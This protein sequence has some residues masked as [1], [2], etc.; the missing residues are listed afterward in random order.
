[1]PWVG[2]VVP[3]I[4]QDVRVDEE[5]GAFPAGDESA[6]LQR[7]VGDRDRRGAHLELGGQPADRREGLVQGVLPVEDPER[8][9]APDLLLEALRGI[10]VEHDHVL[11]HRATSTGVA[12]PHTRAARGSG[13]WPLAA[14][15]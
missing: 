3:R 4:G 12:R 7:L 5:P 14:V 15:R 11:I 13:A 8:D 10:A 2:G 6:L 9:L 1:M